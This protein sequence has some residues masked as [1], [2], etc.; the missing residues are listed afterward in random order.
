M[1]VV[2]IVVRLYMIERF[3]AGADTVVALTAT[4]GRPFE[5]APDMAAVACH[6]FVRPGQREAGGEVVELGRILLLRTGGMCR[7]DRCE[8]RDHWHETRDCARRY[9]E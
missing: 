7:K 9:S 5:L 3:S 6:L 2:A 1:A 8:Q 4:N